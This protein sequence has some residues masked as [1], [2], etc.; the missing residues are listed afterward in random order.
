MMRGVG[1][2][3]GRLMGVGILVLLAAFGM[4][5]GAMVGAA[6]MNSVGVPLPSDAA[7]PSKQV[8]T[9]IGREGTYLDWSKTVQKSQWMPGLM[10]D[11]LVMQDRNSDIKPLSAERWS[12]SSDGRTWTF[13]LRPGLQ[14]SDGTPLSAQDFV[15]TIQRMANPD[16][17]FDVAW[18]F[19]AVKNFK[20]ANEG[21]VPVD[22][23]G[24]SA[25]NATTLQITTSEPTPY[26]LMLLSDLYVVPQ[27]VVS[28]AGDPWSQSPTTAVS[29][30]PFKLASW[31]RDKEVVYAANPMYRGIRKPL[32]EKIVYKIGQDQAFFPAYLAGEVDAIP[33]IYE[34]SLSSSDIARIQSDPRLKKEGRTWPYFQTWW[35]AFGGD[36]TA[37]KDPRVRKAFAMAIDREAIIKSVLRGM[38]VPAYGMLPPGFHCAEPSRLK[39]FQPYNPAA[40]RRLLA[41]A[42]YPDGK[43]FPK[44][45]LGLRAASPTIQNAG[46]AIQAMIKQNLGIDLGV[47]NLERKL[48]MDRLNKYELPIVIIPWEYDYADASNF[49]N[50]YKTG[51]RH[52]W[53]NA[54][55]DKLVNEANSTMSDAQRCSLY[56]KAEE[57]LV[58]EPGALFLW[59][60]SVVQLWKPW[61][62]GEVNKTN[63]YGFVSWSR[64]SKADMLP[65]IY[66]SR[67]KP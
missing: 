18:Y 36:Q 42:G 1:E 51:G 53:S 6:T 14:W 54:E 57:V 11:P 44:Y 45:D 39:N 2:L 61:V 8:L 30:G 9:L 58:R 32:L 24:V 31:D 38:A 22:Q 34:G 59:H 17:G 23:I 37:F 56:R 35:I 3:L 63:K 33:W 28:K 13:F 62:Q 10:T 55:Y 7:P 46:E 20:E 19:S 48:F 27:H 67:D 12:V 43:G 40:A 47:Q 5:P 66:I 15:Y 52:P 64:P 4:T 41:E 29:S 50:I 21:K 49:M 16:T 60:P 25:V 26:L 65:Y